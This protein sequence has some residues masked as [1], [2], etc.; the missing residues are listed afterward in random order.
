MAFRTAI[1][2]GI[3]RTYDDYKNDI[4][5]DKTMINELM[6][7]CMKNNHYD[8]A[9]CLIDKNIFD[10]NKTNIFGLSA[11]HYS[12]SN[13]DIKLTKL[14]LDS[15]ANVNMNPEYVPVLL[16][17]INKGYE[18]FKLLLSY[19]ANV[20]ILCKSNIHDIANIPLLAKCTNLNH[21]KIFDE[22][23]LLTN[24]K[25][26]KKCLQL[27]LPIILKRKIEDRLRNIVHLLFP[28]KLC[29][30]YGCLGLPVDLAN[31]IVNYSM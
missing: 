9:K 12:V 4:M 8:E 28:G 19:G 29:Y 1:G 15:G 13:N 10:I 17:S 7:V 23:L 5:G 25:H 26:L 31:I 30:R 20:N 16:I 11:L 22:I 18:I 27:D 14:L 3:M 24:Y 6:N 2:M 21:T